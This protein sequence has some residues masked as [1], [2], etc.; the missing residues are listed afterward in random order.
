MERC[1]CH[2]NPIFGLLPILTAQTRY[3]KNKTVKLQ[4]HF[5]ASAYSDTVGCVVLKT[6]PTLLQSHFRAS[7]YSDP[8]FAASMSATKP[9][10][11][12]IFGLLPI[13]TLV[14]MCLLFELCYC[15]PIFGLL[16]ILTLISRDFIGS[17]TNC[18]PIFGLLPILTIRSHH[19][20]ARLSSLQS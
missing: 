16:P 20:R 10:C 14:M 6:P 2:C 9:Y 7:A 15:N 8:C 13:L 18:N 1:I 12:P 17:M 3:G 11:N 19:C 4:S 5:R